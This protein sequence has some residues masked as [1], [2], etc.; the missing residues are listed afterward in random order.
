MFYASC[1]FTTKLMALDSRSL[2]DFARDLIQPL[3]DRPTMQ[4]LQSQ[5]FEKQEI[6]GALHQIGWFAHVIFSVTENRCTTS[7]PGKQAIGT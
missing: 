6:Q 4:R 2:Q 7:L 1:S 3:T 5:N